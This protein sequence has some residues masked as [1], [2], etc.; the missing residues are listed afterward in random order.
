MRAN[1]FITDGV[2][3]PDADYINELS[4]MIDMANEEYQEYLD[5]NN[6]EDD[7]DELASIME[8]IFDHYGVPIEVDVGEAGTKAVDLF[9]Q[10]AI[11]A[12]GGEILLTLHRDSIEFGYW[13]PKTFKEKVIKTLEHEDIH[14]R[15]RDRMGSEKYNTL[16]SGYQLGL[17]K[18]EKTG[19]EQDLIRTY[20]RDPQELMAHGHDLALEIQSSN[21][22]EEALRNPEKY[23]DELPTY[24]K[25][26]VIFPP[27]AKPLQRLISYAARYLNN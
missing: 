23:R 5:D 9:I 21:D 26:R 16:P 2:L 3:Q 24:D 25:H 8:H 17:R 1:E 11:V 15:Q 4:W 12:G 7:A 10:D 14:L 22:P 27:N 20:L 13:G 19:K 6:D 18:K